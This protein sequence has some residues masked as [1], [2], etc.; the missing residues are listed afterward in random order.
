MRG[1]RAEEVDPLLWGYDR[2]AGAVTAAFV[3]VRRDR[4]LAVGGLDET[5]RNDFNDVDLC[6]KLEANGFRTLYT[7]H[8]R[9]TH[10][11]S[12]T[13]AY[14]ALDPGEVEH[15]FARWA[16]RFAVDPHVSPHLDRRTL[17]PLL[18]LRPVPRTHG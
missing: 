2:R 14:R 15:M 17:K 10:H 1:C 16:G 8:V 3:A 4:Y 5:L 18:A 9:V 11:E 12:V 6:L 7:P 13:R